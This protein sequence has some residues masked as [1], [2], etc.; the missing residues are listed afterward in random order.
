MPC[1]NFCPGL[2]CWFIFLIIL[3]NLNSKAK[4]DF[5][6][7]SVHFHALLVL[8]VSVFSVVCVNGFLFIN[9]NSF[10]CPYTLRFV[11]VI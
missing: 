9:I 1:H 8:S 3:L 4:S 2:A 5:H 7:L 11:V 10:I 6:W